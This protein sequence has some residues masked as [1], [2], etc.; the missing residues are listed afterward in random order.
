MSDKSVETLGSKTQFS[1]SWKHF[2]PLPLSPKTMLIFLF[3]R[4]HRPQ[5]LHNIEWGGGGGIRDLT[6]DA[7]KIEQMLKYRKSSFPKVSQ[8]LLSLIVASFGI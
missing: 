5:C 3:F 6:L 2:P 8:L 7:N 1:V 4:L